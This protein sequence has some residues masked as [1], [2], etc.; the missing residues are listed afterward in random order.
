M[1]ISMKILVCGDRNWEKDDVI[2]FFLK[3]FN[4]TEIISGGAT[5]AD[6]SAKLFSQ[7]YNIPIKEILPDWN[8]Y[9][10][11]A[12]PIRNMQMLD[13]NPDIVLAFHNNF[14]FSKG[15]KHCAQTAK[16]RNIPVYLI[17]DE[18]KEEKL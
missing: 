9:G 12:G 3:K 5:G 2:E 8:A 6:S 17:T 11:A 14:A 1:A 16:K 15:T 18:Y 10:R 13:L 7:K 4:V